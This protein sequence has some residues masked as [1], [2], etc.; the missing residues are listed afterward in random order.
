MFFY[1]YSVDRKVSKVV[2]NSHQVT[3]GNSQDSQ[4]TIVHNRAE[5]RLNLFFRI[6]SRI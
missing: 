4:N 6:F 2:T 5:H 1:P 3:V